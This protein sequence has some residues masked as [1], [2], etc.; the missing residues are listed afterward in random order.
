MTIKVNQEK[1]ENI[2]KN[3][4]SE[5]IGSKKSYYRTYFNFDLN[6]KVSV[7]HRWL[8]YCCICLDFSL[9]DS[10]LDIPCFW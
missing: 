10:R 4:G 1:T 7:L 8:G 6:Y 2:G 9:V 5:S 3:I